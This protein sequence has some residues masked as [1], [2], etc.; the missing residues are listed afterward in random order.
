MAFEHSQ[1]LK[2]PLHWWERIELSVTSSFQYLANPGA[3]SLV[4]EILHGA[5]MTSVLALRQPG[6][7]CGGGSGGGGGPSIDQS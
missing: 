1:V 4:G 6:N 2:R 3:S 5:A 7:G